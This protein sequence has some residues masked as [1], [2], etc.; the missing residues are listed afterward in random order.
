M[1]RLK[2]LL[3]KLLVAIALWAPIVTAQTVRPGVLTEV[4]ISNSDLNDIICPGQI[5]DVLVSEEKGVQIKASG[6]HAFIKLPVTEQY[7]ERSYATDPVDLVVVCAGEVYKLLAHPDR[8][9]MQTI[10]LSAPTAAV[11]TNLREAAG[12]PLERRVLTLLMGAYRDQWPEAWSVLAKPAL[13]AMTLPGLTLTP[14]RSLSIDGQGLVLD[15]FVVTAG[16]AGGAAS[17][18]ISLNE[19]D[20]L[21]MFAG[22]R[23][24]LALAVDPLRLTADSQGRL[25]VVMRRL[26]DAQ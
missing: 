26:E 23:P 7:G 16:A 12:M 19:A 2:K 11:A 5:E 18:D 10:T 15:E 6:E 20:L 17:A 4:D 8:I 9:P 21:P 3:K 1:N 25:F 13:P 22:R 24:V 14:R